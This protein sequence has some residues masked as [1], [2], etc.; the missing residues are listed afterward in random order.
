LTGQSIAT[1]RVAERA[2]IGNNRGVQIALATVAPAI[3]EN[4]ITFVVFGT[5]AFSLVMSLLFFVTRGRDSMYDQ[6]GQGGLTRES[7]YAG[8]GLTGSEATAAV[9]AEQEQ[10][11]RQMLGARNE[12]LVRSGKPAL[13]I[14]AEVA[15]LLAP[16][17]DGG[18]HDPHLVE[19]VRQLVVARNERRQRQG[20]EPLDVDDEVERT[21]TELDP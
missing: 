10:E 7:D 19:E 21:L 20:L 14:D 5:V 1:A 11:I 2:R 13:D 9:Q 3:A 17:A 4:G 12:R 6:I 16:P 8:P 18:G 15:R